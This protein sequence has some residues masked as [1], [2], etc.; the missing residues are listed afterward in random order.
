MQ[1][2][3]E[4]ERGQTLPFWVIGILVV[5]SMMFFLANYANA[6]AWQIRA[7]NAADGAA[8]GVLAVQANVYNEYSTL[9]YATAVD[10]YRVRTLNQAILDTVYQVGGCYQTSTCDSDYAKLVPAYNNA[11]YAFTKDVNL[12]E[13]A[14][15]LAQA[16][17]NTDESKA[18]TLI[19]NGGWC[20]GSSDYACSFTIHVL[21]DQSVTGNG[22]GNNNTYIGPGDNEVDLVACRNV[23]YFGSAL[24]KLG[25]SAK[26]QVWGRAAAAVLPVNKEQFNPGQQINP[27]TGQP[28]QPVETSWA[29]DAPADP[30]Y[31]VD[32]SGLTVDVNWYQAG[33]IHPYT[34][35]VP[36]SLTCEGP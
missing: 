1:L 31:Q 13:Q 25:D 26:Y 23:G 5:L 36:S 18:L 24:L 19:Q 33:T 4:S 30:D 9:L 11:V 7:Q 10:E 22:N 32:Y 17:Q 2:S 3:H 29:P 8:S 28:Y 34:T 35:T 20:S 21:N 12:L 14:N 27:Q 15:N 6:V 16:G